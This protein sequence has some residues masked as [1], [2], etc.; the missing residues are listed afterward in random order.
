MSRVLHVWIYCRTKLPND[1]WN[2]LSLDPGLHGLE[3]ES[4]STG[5]VSCGNEE[6]MIVNFKFNFLEDLY[7]GEGRRVG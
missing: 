3:A 2:P 4:Q 6:A 1:Y 7:M 5:K